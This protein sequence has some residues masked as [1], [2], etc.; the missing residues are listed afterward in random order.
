MPETEREKT[1]VRRM[2]EWKLNPCSTENEIKVCMS[3]CAGPRQDQAEKLNKSRKTFYK[4][5]YKHFFCICTSMSQNLLSPL[6]G[7]RHISPVRGL[8]QRHLTESEFTRY[9]AQI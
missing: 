6:M 1:R 7:I 4:T 2:G 9:G 8:F 3:R 5:L